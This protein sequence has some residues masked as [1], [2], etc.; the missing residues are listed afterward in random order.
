MQTTTLS[1]PRLFPLKALAKEPFVV[2]TQHEEEKEEGYDEWLRARL[3]KTIQKLDSG[4]MPRYTTQE[5]RAHL[6]VRREQWCAQGNA[7]NAA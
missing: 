5:V 6:K 3:E 4:E 7:L 1:T 2:A